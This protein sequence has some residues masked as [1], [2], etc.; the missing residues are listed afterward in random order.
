MTAARV[1]PRANSPTVELAPIAESDISEIAAF[2]AVQSKRSREAVE[3]HLRWFLLENPAREPEQPLGFGL[4]S[5]SGI[6]G[7]ILCSPQVFRL[8]ARRM[9][10]M[11]S[12]SFY[13]HEDFRGHGGR[14]FLQYSRLAGRWPIFGTSANAM[15]AA[16]WK[17]AGA[18]P[19]PYSDGEMLGVIRWQPVAEELVHRRG[20]S[21]F[22][23][24]IAASSISGVMAQFRRLKID[25][26]NPEAL[27]PL[28][29][30][31]QV[32]DVVARHRAEKLTALR[33]AAYIQWRYF[34]GRDA[35]TA[36]F[37]FRDA[38]EQEI[39]VTVNQ[40]K[41]GHRRQINTL[42][43][44]DVFPKVSAAQWVKIVGALLA[45][46]GDSIDAVVLRNLDPETKNIFRKK[47]FQWRTF[48]APN[49]WLLDKTKVLPSHDWY[50]V[51]AD[52]DGLI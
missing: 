33:D 47:G 23:G 10:M 21:R 45:G 6:A 14:I 32:G 29:C 5:P 19:L 49:G 38:S 44:L 20:S 51:P 39:L 24:S 12:S 11:G 35:T 42:N 9:V 48:D 40:R 4:R 41:R 8:G 17:A 31:E 16:L 13:V 26:Q 46:Y 50:I 15:A 22:L 7:C 25:D 28:T 18:A 37:A 43:L 36:V 52:G 1:I 3:S 27:C 34:S 2:I 30:A